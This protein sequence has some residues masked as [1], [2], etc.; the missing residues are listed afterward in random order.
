[1]T[2]ALWLFLA[3]LVFALLSLAQRACAVAL[4]TVRTGDSSGSSR[5]RSFLDALKADVHTN[6]RRTYIDASLVIAAGALGTAILNYYY[7]LH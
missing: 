2:P 4:R 5:S 1:M 7:G 3:L 6:R